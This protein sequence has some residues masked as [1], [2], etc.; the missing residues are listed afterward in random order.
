MKI[1][2]ILIGI[3]LIIIWSI[4]IGRGFDLKER[5]SWAI[6]FV[7]FLIG[8][9][10]GV[11]SNDISSGLQGGILFSLLTMWMG[12]VMLAHKQRYKQ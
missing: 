2:L 5:A 4:K 9:L 6:V 7:G 8:F 3:T 10:P 11:V 12:P 1:V